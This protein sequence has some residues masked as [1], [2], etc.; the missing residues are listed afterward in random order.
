MIK[1]N[2][3]RILNTRPKEQGKILH[4]E[5]HQA[6]G[7]SIDFPTLEIQGTNPNWLA[8][9]PDLSTITHAIFISVNA[10]HYFF[11][12]LQKRQIT[13]V[14]DIHVIAIGQSTAR[15]L[16]YK[17]GLVAEVP[18]TP[19]SEHLL[20]L[21][22]LKKLA[23]QSILLIKGKGGRTLIEDSLL[24]QGV[25]LVILAVYQ[26]VLPVINNQYSNSLWRDD[27]VDIILLTSEQ[28]IHNLFK[29]FSQKAHDWLKNKPCLVISERLAQAASQL[30]MSKIILSHPN[31]ILNTLLDY[32]DYIHGGQQ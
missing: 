8:N 6:G 27:A 16:Q 25:D 24:N 3:L 4:E 7:I 10:V 5:I 9:L 1:L 18:P 21:P 29:L 2:G 13:W 28:S 11:N 14:K 19:D 22:S 15:T 17:Y 26:R 30:G 23:Q 12:E 20:Q 32:K 31:Q